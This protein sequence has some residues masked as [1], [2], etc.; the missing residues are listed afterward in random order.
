MTLYN[1]TNLTGNPVGIIKFSDE[2]TG[3][4]ASTWF[5]LAIYVIILTA[6][7]TRHSVKASFGAAGFISGILGIL[8]FIIGFATPVLL[9]ISIVMILLTAVFL[10]S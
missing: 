6:L 2:V 1:M 9:N 10:F 3:G 8:M 7:I 5:L 4:Q